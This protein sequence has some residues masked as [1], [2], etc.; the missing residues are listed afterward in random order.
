MTTAPRMRSFLH[1]L[2]KTWSIR[3]R[4]AARCGSRRGRDGSKF[5]GSCGSRCREHR[6]VEANE[7]FINLKYFR[8]R[9]AVR[10]NSLVGLS[11]RCPHCAAQT[12]LS[13][14][15]PFP[16]LHRSQ[17]R[18]SI[19][20]VHPLFP[21]PS[22]TR[23]W[24]CGCGASCTR[25]VAGSALQCDEQSLERRLCCQPMG[26]CRRARHNPHIARRPELDAGLY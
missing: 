25:N 19:D 1:M 9:I 6:G 10:R 13:K 15:A 16:S 4:R 7:D 3:C 22:C 23:E 12:I 21:E 17:A 20:H 24:I 14:H 5:R 26:D 2:A 11:R 18:I 8:A